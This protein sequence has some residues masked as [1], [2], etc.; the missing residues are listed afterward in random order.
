MK[1]VHPRRTTVPFPLF[2]RS[3]CYLLFKRF[4]S[5]SLQESL[6]KT[7]VIESTDLEYDESIRNSKQPNSSTDHHQKPYL[8]PGVAQIGCLFAASALA[9][10]MPIRP[11]QGCDLAGLT[12][13]RSPKKSAST[14]F[15]GVRLFAGTRISTIAQSGSLGIWRALLR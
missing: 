9:S 11:L 1:N 3:L 13:Q 6:P 2:L 7:A 8:N 15:P 10:G 12:S 5:S 14:I 4:F